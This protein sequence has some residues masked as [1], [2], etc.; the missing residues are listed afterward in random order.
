MILVI[1]CHGVGSAAF[2][3]AP[4]V[5]RAWRSAS[6]PEPPEYEAIAP[7]ASTPVETVEPAPRP[8]RRWRLPRRRSWG[9]FLLGGLFGALGVLFLLAAIA[10][11][12]AV[13][14]RKDL[15]LERLYGDFAVSLAARLHAGGVPQQP[16]QNPRALAEAQ[17]SYLTCAQCHG[18][19]GKGDGVYGRGT[20][21]NATD[22]TAGDAKEKSDAEL[23]WITKNGLSFTGMPGFGGQFSDQD[24]WQL[25]MYMRALQNG[26]AGAPVAVPTASAQQLSAANPAGTAPEQGAA[27]YFAQG[28]QA[29]HGPAGNAPRNLAIRDTREATQAIREGRQGMPAYGQD[30]LSD[31]DLQ[32]LIAYMNTFN[33]RGR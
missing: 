13:G 31:A 32:K 12:L 14:H 27:I 5:A 20:Y 21:P 28:C 25:V 4:G 17:A 26:Q 30:K 10:M 7:T 18:P 23:F 22:L 24:I 11:P 15:P 6:M 33:N 29:C 2:V 1:P 3:A 19:T 16:A 9:L 8:G